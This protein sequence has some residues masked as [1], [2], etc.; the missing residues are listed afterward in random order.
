MA[1]NDLTER[2][3]NL[4]LRLADE[5]TNIIDGF[6]HDDLAPMVGC[7]RESFSVIIDRFRRAGAI[8]TG[9]RR[10]ELIDRNHL[11]RIVHERYADHTLINSSER[12]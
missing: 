2:V 9:R 6:S 8:L 10:I 5:N 3:A 7:R 4:L 11:D 1:F 12:I